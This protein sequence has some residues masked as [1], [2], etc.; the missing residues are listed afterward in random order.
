L[1]GRST[2]GAMNWTQGLNFATSLSRSGLLG[3]KGVSID[4]LS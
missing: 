2:L 1:F 4:E 3:V